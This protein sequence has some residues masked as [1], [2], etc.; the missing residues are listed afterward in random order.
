MKRLVAVIGLVVT[1]TLI[2]YGL[3]LPDEFAEWDFNAYRA[4]IYAGD[5]LSMGRHLVADFG[6]RIVPGYY[7]P[8]SSISLMMDKYLTGEAV[9]NP[10]I[11][12]F[13]NILLHCING[14]L[15]FAL[16]RVLK[17]GETFCGIAV[18]VFLI[19]PIQVESVIWFAQRKT[20]LGA[21]FCFLSWISF[22]AFRRNGSKALYG[23]SLVAFGLGV[24]SKPTYICLPALLFAT[25]ILL[26]HDKALAENTCTTTDGKESSE[27]QY[28]QGLSPLVI[29]L[30]P[31]F[32][33]ALGCAAATVMTEP[34]A[35]V[36]LPW[37]ERPFIAAAALWFYF[38]KLVLPF[39]LTVVYPRWQIDLSSWIW[40]ALLAGIIATGALLWKFRNQLGRRVLWAIVVFLIPLV[41]AIGFFKFGH[42]VHSFVGNQFLYFS[43]IG[44]ACLSAQAFEYCL[45]RLSPPLKYVIIGAGIAFCGLLLFQT[46]HRAGIWNNTYTLWVDNS[47]YNPDFAEG[48]LLIGAWQL[49]RGNLQEA[50]E[51]SRKALKIDPKN[52]LAYNNL[53]LVKKKQGN[54]ADAE[55]YFRRALEENSRLIVALNNLARVFDATGRLAEAVNLYEEALRQK[56]DFPPVLF[57]LA[58]A[59]F[60]L[61]RIDDA[62]EAYSRLVHIG[63]GSAAVHNMLGVLLMMRGEREQGIVQ[64]GK[65]LV[66]DPNYREARM[67]LESA[68]Q[69]TSKTGNQPE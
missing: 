3:N 58:D 45:P 42:Q 40:W 30:V 48:P 4:V 16:L 27:I 53:G 51:Y 25:E 68:I 7:A 52:A 55:R 57:N 36:P 14:I 22:L 61:N 18:V 20:V 43:M 2:L 29:Q 26:T 69:E 65:A 49:E 8:V 46:E 64:F 32:A 39:S 1:V 33:L 6:G 31:Y 9:P 21:M 63:S 37:Y 15:L 11:T 13:V 19:H 66:I 35:S 17:A 62:T 47:K 60:R 34:T 41:P 44:V 10:K 24:L 12:A 56:P 50:E 59:L 5:P 23:L 38:G 54:N 67:N 28:G